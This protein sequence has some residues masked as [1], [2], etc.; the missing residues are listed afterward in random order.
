MTADELLA[1]PKGKD[2]Y[3]LVKGELITLPPAGGE[4]GS[5]TMKITIRLALFIEQHGLGECFSA[6]TGFIVSRD[7]DTVRAPDFS[8]ILKER[9]PAEGIPRAFLSVV[10]TLVLEVLSPGDSV[11]EVEE[12]IEDWLEF[13]VDEVWVINPRRKSVTVYAKDRDPHTVRSG[14]IIRGSGVL[15]A[16]SHPV[17]DLFPR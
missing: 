9:I 13:G 12:K 4:H 16:F 10:P 5:I 1:L 7:P 8:F 15:A 3:E 6:E 17:A 2:R 11:I 14:D